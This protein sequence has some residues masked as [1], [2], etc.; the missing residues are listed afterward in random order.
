MNE[1]RNDREQEKERAPEKRNGAR[2]AKDERQRGRPRRGT[3]PEFDHREL[4]RLLVHGEFVDEEGGRPSH[5]YPSYRELADRFG[6]GTTFINRFARRHNCL[7]RRAGSGAAVEPPPRP[8][9]LQARATSPA[10]GSSDASEAAVSGADGPNDGDGAAPDVVDARMMPTIREIFATW[11]RAVQAG[12]IRIT[13]AGEIE[14]MMR[15][16]ADLDAEA[17]MRALIPEGVPTLDELQDLYEARMAAYEASSPAERGEIPIGI[18]GSDVVYDAPRPDDEGA[19]GEL[20][21]GER[22]EC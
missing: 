17:Q 5:R 7:E 18:P 1:K 21:E 19:A 22:D 8:G 2:G 6:V 10:A 11:V 16:A 4:E 9:A 14:K 15:I 12:E 13:S 3:E 20:R